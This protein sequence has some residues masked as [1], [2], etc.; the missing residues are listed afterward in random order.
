[1][2]VSSI[3]PE[4][5]VAYLIVN[6]NH[7]RENIRIAASFDDVTSEFIKCI[8]ALLMRHITPVS[9]YWL[10][11]EVFPYITQPILTPQVLGREVYIDSDIEEATIILLI[12]PFGCFARFGFQ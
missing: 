4:Q 5:A 2:S 3:R 11:V 8:D 1:M 12:A 6:L 10:V 9:G 7:I